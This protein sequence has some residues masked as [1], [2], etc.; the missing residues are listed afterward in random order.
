MDTDRTYRL[1][2]HQLSWPKA[3]CK[4]HA[5]SKRM[6]YTKMCVC[7]GGWKGAGIVKDKSKVSTGS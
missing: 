1:M 4:E 7:W 6:V 5:L 2:W 3:D